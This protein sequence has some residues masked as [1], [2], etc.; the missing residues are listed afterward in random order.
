MDELN[1]TAAVEAMLVRYEE[2]PSTCEHWDRSLSD[3]PDMCRDCEY[4][5]VLEAAA[6]LIERAVREQAAQELVAWADSLDWENNSSL[7]RLRRHVH[8]CAQRIGPK[9]TDRE[10]AEAL[11]RGDFV[12]CHLDDAGRAIPPGERGTEANRG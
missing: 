10:V 3:Y 2:I 11:V 12:G 9:M 8:M 4:R 5:L 6:P 7:R 1:L